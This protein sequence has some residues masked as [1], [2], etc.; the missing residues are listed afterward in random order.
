MQS[1]F[2]KPSRSAPSARCGLHRRHPWP[3]D[4]GQP[5]WQVQWVAFLR[6]NGLTGIPE[7]CS[8]VAAALRKFLEPVLRSM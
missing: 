7:R 4:K 3:G 5:F 6:R 8:E 2:S 1:R